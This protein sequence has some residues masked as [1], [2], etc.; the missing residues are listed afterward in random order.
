MLFGKVRLF[1]SIQLKPQL[2]PECLPLTPM[3]IAAGLLPDRTF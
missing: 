2:M 3:V 1:E